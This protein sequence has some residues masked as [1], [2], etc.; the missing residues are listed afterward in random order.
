MTDRIAT[1]RSWRRRLA[2]IGLPALW[3]LASC[4]AQN[5]DIPNRVLD[6]PLDVAL[7]CVHVECD[8][9]G[10]CHGEA[11]SLRECRGE[12]G[13]CST[14][15]NHLVGFVA[16][17]E[18]NEIAVFTQC[19]GDLVDMD[20]EA[21]GY[22][23][24][25]VGTLPSAMT[26]S[27]D[28]CR[29]ISANAGSCDLSVLDAPNLGAFGLNIRTPTRLSSNGNRVPVEPSSLVANVA[30][31]RLDPEDGWVPVAAR[32]GSIVSVPRQLSN[33]GDQAPPEDPILDACGPD[34]PGSVYVSFPSCN[35]VAEVDLVSHRVLQSFQFEVTDAGVEV[36]DTGVN[37]E[38]PVDCP[39][40]FEDGVPDDLPPADD[41]GLNPVTIELVH[42]PVG[43]DED[44]MS[45]DDPCTD[46][47]DC[48]VQDPI[49]LVGGLGSDWVV[50]IPIDEDTREWSEDVLS[51]ELVGA[52]GI[53]RIRATP[54]MNGPTDP[55][56]G[57]VYQF[58]YVVAGDGSTRVVR[59]DLSPDRGAVG[60]E[61]DTQVDPVFALDTPACYPVTQTPVGAQPPDR[62]AFANGPG[63]RVTDNARVTDWVFKKVP[64][65][66]LGCLD[67][68]E[69]S[70]PFGG[71]GRVVGV[72]TT[73]QGRIVY[74]T[75]GQ[76]DNVESLG[77]ELDPV[78]LMDVGI[79]WHML[80][81]E[82]APIPPAGGGR[83][84]PL[85]LPT[86]ADE[87]P[88]RRL[89]EDSLPNRFLSP[90]FRLIDYAY[91]YDEEVNGDDEDRQTLYAAY[92]VENVDKMGGPEALE[93]P[94]A[95][96]LFK[97]PVVRVHARDYRA[98]GGNTFELAWEGLVPGAASATGRIVCEEPGWPWEPGD[99]PE[100]AATCRPQEDGDSRLLDEGA[101]FC[102]AGVL[103]G[104]KLVLLGCDE[105][106]DCGE[107]QACLEEAGSLPGTGI[108]VSEQ[109]VQQDAQY[110]REVCADF[111]SDP[112]GEPLREF[113]ITRAFRNELWLQAMNR[114]P[115]EYI[116]CDV[117]EDD[118]EDDCTSDEITVHEDTFVCTEEQPD[119]GCAS[120]SD[121]EE[122][123]P[124]SLCIE[125]RCR[126]PC[127]D[128]NGCLLMRLP[129]P[130]CFREFVRYQ[131]R[132]R[133]AFL[134]TG[135]GPTAFLSDQVFA[136]QDSLSPYS[137]S[138]EC[139]LSEPQAG[140]SSL[141]TS[142]IPLGPDE[143]HLDLP[144]CPPSD[145][146]PS[147]AS[148]N[149]CLIEQDRFGNEDSRF[150]RFDYGGM[151]KPVMAVRYTN[152]VMSVIIDLV[153]LKALGTAIPE[154]ERTL[155]LQ[156]M[157]EGTLWPEEFRHFK[158]SRI[159]RG[160]RMEFGATPGYQPINTG[161]GIGSVGLTFP[162]RAIASPDLNWV[163][164]VDGSG[165]GTSTAV[166]GQVL[167]VDVASNPPLADTSFDGVR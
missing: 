42:P 66:T 21:P 35:T 53:E 58:L 142:R 18:R 143:D 107:G 89:P 148:V 165:P 120:D 133:N 117:D 90:G 88:I 131:V 156:R 48:A 113:S 78:E 62:R 55:E 136:D 116:D 111:I 114:P 70:V 26:Q 124:G 104:D 77:D 149:P 12:T 44:C 52:A 161:V 167:R 9:E 33:S 36:I 96:G 51:L 155:G 141:L 3:I 119:G 115:T 74:S 86:V 99:P 7:T 25:P 64:E 4:P 135:G 145:N 123:A 8:D 132:A 6:R 83:V 61:C 68:E 46:A 76:F 153:D 127:D 50:E 98:W 94:S 65:D 103:A 59:R 87:K 157:V 125:D 139:T 13:S 56:F 79:R 118:K 163:F 95:V 34:Q 40:V 27:T 128:P 1:A 92:G 22:N 82:F 164:V 122:V 71:P 97:E 31:R 11:A 81:P 19:A 45:D 109:A 121:C 162:V 69:G 80:Y 105:D 158:R 137:G 28:G 17:S 91:T 152:P 2:W 144:A 23:F 159:P 37:P 160:Y 20:V 47:A 32:P 100:T 72:G 138:P 154:S 110:L 30:P 108:C 14:S 112:C 10:E 106:T 43:A 101:D 5:Q 151:D 93:E 60:I 84:E 130:A 49:L 102:S 16:N 134:V 73:N 29:A 57:S 147:A 140:I 146:N 24:I 126:V 38:C 67:L 75:M 85:T 166:R 129:G 150:H 54:A 15:G 39:D 63:I 41:G